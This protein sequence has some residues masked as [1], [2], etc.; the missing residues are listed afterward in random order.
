MHPMFLSDVERGDHGGPYA[1]LIDK[2]Q[3]AGAPVPQIMHLFAYKPDR[4]E[5]LSRFTQ[6]VMR[7]P[8][9]LPAGLREL[10]AAFTSRRN[11][12]LF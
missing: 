7:G 10:I 6:S 9:P 12:C 8:S 1:H 11:D 2:L 4:T 3:A 5:F